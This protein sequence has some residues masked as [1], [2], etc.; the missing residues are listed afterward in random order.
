MIKNNGC[1][2]LEYAK[3]LKELGVKQESLWYWNNQGLGHG[4][5]GHFR[6]DMSEVSLFSVA[7]LGEMLPFGVV[8]GKTRTKFSCQLAMFAD[9]N[10]NFNLGLSNRDIW[11]I[12]NTGTEV[13]ARAKMLIYLLENKMMEV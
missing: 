10:N 5:I 2:D 11:D 3:K 1:C 4:H 12:S 6:N 7:E 13:N 9:E 8:S